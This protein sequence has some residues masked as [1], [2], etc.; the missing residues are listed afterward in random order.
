MHVIAVR[1]VHEALPEAIAHLVHNGV[2]RP[3]R[4]GDVLVSP[5]PVTT[6]YRQPRERV[7]F[8]PERDANP[9]HN[10]ME[11]LWMLAGYNHVEWPA[12]FAR[13]MRTFS[14]DGVVLHGAY[15]FRWRTMF[16]FDQL[17]VIAKRLRVDPDCRRQVLQIW[18]STLDLRN[19]EGKKDLPCNIAVTFQI[20]VLG[21]LDMTVFNRSNDII[22][23]TYGADAVH[24]SM[25][26]EYMAARIGVLPGLYW[27]VSTNWHGYIK[28]LDP[29]VDIA[30]QRRMPPYAH[31]PHPN[32]YNELGEPYALNTGVEDMDVWD[33]E[34]L[35]F[36]SEGTNAAGYR[37]PY[38]KRIALPMLAAHDAY[39]EGDL[40]R[41]LEH[42][43]RI[44][45]ADLKRACAEWIERR[46]ERRKAAGL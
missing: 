23:G 16:G 42:C 46:I 33:S 17:K 9:F 34:L 37:I 25:L 32:P 18:G 35:M 1:N 12:R 6:L 5:E 21:H 19:Q 43:G 2:K 44:G 11:G 36:L 3:S 39:K 30:N 24:F 22:W 7:L 29:L 28:T 41:A 20:S 13:R 26:Q 14:D 15:G 10:V 27:Q 38:F 4:A 45:S 8:W 40:E 31:A